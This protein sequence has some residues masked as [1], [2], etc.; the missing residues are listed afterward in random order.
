MSGRPPAVD[1]KP[2]VLQMRALH[3]SL[4]P[5][6]LMLCVCVQPQTLHPTHMPGMREALPA[7]SMS[8]VEQWA[9]SWLPPLPGVHVG[10]R[11]NRLKCFFRALK[12]AA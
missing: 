7:L 3:T 2:S 8:C 6:A 12:L 4:H 11:M 10:V 1:E 9:G 5:V